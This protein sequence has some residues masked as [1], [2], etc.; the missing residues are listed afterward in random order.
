M[1][2][3][4]CSHGGSGALSDGQIVVSGLTKQYRNVRA[5]DNLSFVV[6]PGRVTGFLGPNGAGK[7]TT[8]RMML[9]LVSPTAGTATI[10][11]HRYADVAEPLQLVGAILEASAAHKGRTARN[12]LRC[13]AAAGG[14]PAARVD[15]VLE[16]VGLTT[17]AKR[18]FRGYSLGMKQRLGIAQALLG[19]P[20][21]LILDEP[22]N[23]LD[24]EGIRWMRG[25]LQGLA[26]QGRTVLVSSHLLSEME[27]LA[28]DVVIIAAGKLVTQGPV[29]KIIGQGTTQ[30][31]VRVR[32]PNIQELVAAVR[33]AGGAIN[34]NGNGAHLVTGLDAPA[35]GKLAL[36]AGVELHELMAERPDLEH[37]F[38]E[39]TQGRA[40][41]R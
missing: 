27:I 32:T 10:S 3:F 30:G 9:N 34:P 2:A 31:A 16:L 26:Q 39:L 25:L 28:D 5:V 36:R 7:T 29:D 22:A 1:D 20:K 21:V 14:F 4:T 35:V 18:K 38:L 17:A 37:V 6:E 40:A 15:E 12:H 41:I 23:G 8:L 24:P 33:E 13:V 11:G 19:D